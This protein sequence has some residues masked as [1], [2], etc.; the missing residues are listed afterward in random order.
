M[1][2]TIMIMLMVLC[3]DMGCKVQSAAETMLDT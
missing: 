1:K 2:K 3:S